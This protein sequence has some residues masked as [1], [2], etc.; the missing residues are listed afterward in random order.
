MDEIIKSNNLSEYS[1]YLEKLVENVK[2][3]TNNRVNL[4]MPEDA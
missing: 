3:A 4:K 2:R 1:T